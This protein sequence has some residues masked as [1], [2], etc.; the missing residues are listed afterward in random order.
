MLARRPPGLGADDAPT[1]DDEYFH[2]M[3]YIFRDTS[4]DSRRTYHFF[5]SPLQQQMDEFFM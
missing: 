2:S 3:L 1:I 5:C 4:A